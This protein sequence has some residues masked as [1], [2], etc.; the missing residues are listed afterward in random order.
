[1]IFQWGNMSNQ[2]NQMSLDEQ[3]LARFFIQREGE[4][5]LDVIRDV[6]FFE[7]GF[8]DSLDMVALAVFV[9]RNFKKR[10]DLTDPETF[11]AMKKFNTL[12]DIISG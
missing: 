8:I 6:D 11:Q 1:M 3:K 4:G 5:I 7:Q 10:L 2:L 12:M 9:E